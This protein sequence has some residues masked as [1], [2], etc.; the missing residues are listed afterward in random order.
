MVRFVERPQ[1]VQVCEE[2][3][4]VRYCAY[5]GYEAL[6]DRW[7]PVVESVLGLVPEEVR[8]RR[9]ELRQR[10]PLRYLDATPRAVRQELS[11]PIFDAG[12]GPRSWE[13]DGALH[14][15]L[16]W[17]RGDDAALGEFALAA[18]TAAWALNV[19][20]ESGAFFCARAG[21]ARTAL[22]LWM[23]GQ[24]TARASSALA[25]A[26]EEPAPSGGLPGAGPEN[27][28][29]VLHGPLWTLGIVDEL[30]MWPRAEVAAALELLDRPVEEVAARVRASWD[31]LS[32]PATTTSELAELFGM[33]IP[34]PVRS[35]GPCP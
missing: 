31:R 26:Y 32:D 12:R 5:P 3:A 18:Q 34:T 17:G 4:G 2:R 14:P 9:L 10:V 20:T 19:P 33:T 35:A 13:D 15:E 28:P 7:A 16:R 29:V 1:D 30:P 11:V 25:L 6:V 23:A 24:T 8:G 22:V 27:F 21:Q